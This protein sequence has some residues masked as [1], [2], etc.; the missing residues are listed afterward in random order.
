MTL[1]LKPHSDIALLSSLKSLFF[2]NDSFI[3]KMA[4]VHRKQPGDKDVCFRKH[5]FH[6]CLAIPITSSF[7]RKSNAVIMGWVEE[8]VRH[9]LIVRR[10]N[11]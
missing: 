10:Q 6:A 9:V 4:W 3:H 1:T 11:F 5:L 8:I 7:L 2:S